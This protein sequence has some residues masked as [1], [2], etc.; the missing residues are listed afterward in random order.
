LK[1]KYLEFI[2]GFAALLVLVNHIIGKLPAISNNRPLILTAIGA[3]GTEAVVVFFV[4]SGVVINHTQSA[5]PQTTSKFLIK[6]AIRI[7]PIYYICVFFAICVD[8][9][10]NVP[11]NSAHVVGTIFFVA[12]LQGAITSPITTIIVVWSLS[13]EAFFYI[14]FSLTIGNRQKVLIFLWFIVSLVCCILYYF[15]KENIIYTYLINMFSFS[16]LWLLGY[17]IYEFR[18]RFKTDLQTA[19][20]A[21]SLIPL[22]NRLQISSEYYNVGI[23]ICIALLTVPMFLLALN[24]NAESDRSAQVFHISFLHYLPFYIIVLISCL[25][26]SRSLLI[27]K[28]LYTSLPILSLSLFIS[29]VQ[30]YFMITIKRIE[31]II[32]FS[33]R[34]SFALYLI[35]VPIIYLLGRLWPE[36][37][38]INL[39]LVISLTYFISILLEFG[40]QKK[41]TALLL[42]KPAS[43]IHEKGT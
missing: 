33:G 23:F 9:I 26:F 3:W 38:F 13:F 14:L 21:L 11:I 15:H 43:N 31:I 22:T 35:H 27:S 2:R 32:I 29:F 8:Y 39:I 10:T 1:Y 24:R 5:K 42:Q 7:L 20:F 28:I 37:I 16:S 36:S 18:N 17:Y 30:R 12:T 6:R 19:I 25:L 41:L 4:L 40:Y 34:I